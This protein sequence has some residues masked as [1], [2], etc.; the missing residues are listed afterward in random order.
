MV[1]PNSLEFAGIAATT[2]EV[3]DVNR[4]AAEKYHGMLRDFGDRENTRSA[5]L[6]IS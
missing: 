4:H 1:L 3:V 2:V 6:W 5:T